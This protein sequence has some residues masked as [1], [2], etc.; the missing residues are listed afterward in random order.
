MPRSGKILKD[1]DKAIYTLYFVKASLCF[2]IHRIFGLP[3]R[4]AICKSPVCLHRVLSFQLSGHKRRNVQST[5]QCWCKK[6]DYRIN[7]KSPELS[8]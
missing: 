3:F 5:P 7:F 1:P 4:K 6:R 8:F 2:T